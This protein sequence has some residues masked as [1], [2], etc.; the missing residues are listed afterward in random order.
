MSYFM[1][2]RERSLGRI[3]ISYGTDRL[4]QASKK[5]SL[6]VVR[7]MLWFVDEYKLSEFSSG[8]ILVDLF[9]GP[10]KVIV[11]MQLNRLAAQRLMGG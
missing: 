5:L 11:L 2:R 3:T 6:D 4:I 9:D 7:R 1:A 8:Q 10:D